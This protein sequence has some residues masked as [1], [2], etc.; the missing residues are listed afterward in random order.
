MIIV[1]ICGHTLSPSPRKIF[2][3]E[4]VDF[5]KISI[6]LGEGE[7]RLFQGTGVDLCDKKYSMLLLEICPLL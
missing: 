4:G 2:Q 6:L 1:C 7:K 3:K 5:G